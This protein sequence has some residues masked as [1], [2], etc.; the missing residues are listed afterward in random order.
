MSLAIRESYSKPES[1][2]QEIAS[3]DLFALKAAP[4]NL[5]LK[6]PYSARPPRD[7]RWF[8]EVPVGEQPISQDRG[9]RVHQSGQQKHRRI[10]EA[11]Y[12]VAGSELR[13]HASYRA[14]RPGNACDCSDLRATIQIGWN[15][16][17][18]RDPESVAKSDEARC[19]DR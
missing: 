15:R 3:V 10:G 18:V 1:M 8:M 17:Q 6:S 16:L 4:R 12:Q 11:G 7:E 2:H 13:D 5:D 14:A 9:K 19:G